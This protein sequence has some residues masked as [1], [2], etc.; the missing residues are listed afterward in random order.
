MEN[1]EVPIGTVSAEY[2]F[3]PILWG[4]PNTYSITPTP[5]FTPKTKTNSV[6]CN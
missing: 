1:M 4:L 2:N 3:K 6:T 5:A